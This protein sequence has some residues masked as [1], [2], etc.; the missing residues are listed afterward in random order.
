MALM[1]KPSHRFQRQA[2][3]DV[4]HFAILPYF[5]KSARIIDMTIILFKGTEMR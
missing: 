3:F 4:S 2:Q 5:R 1:K